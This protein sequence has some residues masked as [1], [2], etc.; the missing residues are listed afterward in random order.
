MAQNRNRPTR[1]RGD[2]RFTINAGLTRG[3]AAAPGDAA[4]RGGPRV[5]VAGWRVAG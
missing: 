3:C 4:W 2:G 5:R 1:L